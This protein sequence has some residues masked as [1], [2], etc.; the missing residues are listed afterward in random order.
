MV[1]HLLGRLDHLVDELDRADEVGQ[2]EGLDDRLAVALPALE[3]GQAGFDLAVGEQLHG[4]QLSA[5][6]RL[7]ARPPGWLHLAGVP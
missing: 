6:P 2:L 7:H 5:R 1:A 4:L 3:L